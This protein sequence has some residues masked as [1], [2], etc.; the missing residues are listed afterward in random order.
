MTKQ[1]EQKTQRAP[2]TGRKPLLAP[3]DVRRL[4]ERYFSEDK[5]S[6]VD[7]SQ[8]F[9]HVNLKG[10]T[11]TLCPATVRKYLKS[12]GVK[13]PRGKATTLPREGQSVQTLMNNIPTQLLLGFGQTQMLLRLFAKG[14][15][16][17]VLSEQY[18]I[19]KARVKKLLEE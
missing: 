19:S 5:P 1:V 15:S 9:T 18:G 16:T 12:T 14:T 10:E 6:I 7:L 17:K 2:S 3:S 8:E 4:L 13:L 11:L